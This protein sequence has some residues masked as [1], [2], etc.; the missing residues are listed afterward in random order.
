[1]KKSIENVVSRD[2]V[3]IIYV[4]SFFSSSLL[5]SKSYLEIKKNLKM[6]RLEL[7]AIISICLR[8]ILSRFS[9]VSGVAEF[10]TDPE[11]LRHCRVSWQAGGAGTPEHSSGSRDVVLEMLFR[12]F[13]FIER[14]SRFMHFSTS[15]KT[16]CR[17][18]SHRELPSKNQRC[19]KF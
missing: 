19:E 14:G 4:T 15:S 13:A 12:G 1:M 10:P 16:I 7:E 9:Y 5:K 18:R 17:N 3:V 8:T 6:L 2:R 11:H